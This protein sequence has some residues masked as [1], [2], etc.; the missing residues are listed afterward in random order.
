MKIEQQD[1]RRIKDYM[2]Q[3]YGINLENKAVLIE[4]RLSNLVLRS[5]LKI[6]ILTLI[7]SFRIRRE[8]RLIFW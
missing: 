3:N 6:F 2:R 7:L 5:G 1:F 4:G 8:S